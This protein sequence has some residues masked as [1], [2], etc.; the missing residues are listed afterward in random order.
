MTGEGRLQ[1][2]CPPDCAH[3]GYLTGV[4]RR[5]GESDPL[6]PA[7]NGGFEGTKIANFP[8]N[9]HWRWRAIENSIACESYLRAPVTRAFS[10]QNGNVYIRE[11]KGSAGP[12]RALAVP[13]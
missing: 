9:E 6:P 2:H 13:N 8:K 7:V 4:R 3:W 11:R 12:D 1:P 10:A 5:I